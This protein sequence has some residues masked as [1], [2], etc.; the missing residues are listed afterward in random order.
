MKGRSRAEIEHR[1]HQRYFPCQERYHAAFGPRERA[2]VVIANEDAASAH[3]L[4]RDLSRLPE[5]LRS[6]VDKVVPTCQKFDT[7]AGSQTA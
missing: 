5:F 1:V 3:A 6:I 2:D 7:Q 4:R